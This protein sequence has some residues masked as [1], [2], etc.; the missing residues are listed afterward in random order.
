MLLLGQSTPFTLNFSW[1]ETS[2]L[3]L[4]ASQ[5]LADI[6]ILDSLYNNVTG[7]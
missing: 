4:A 2:T 1:P 6:V 7:F 5:G 3:R